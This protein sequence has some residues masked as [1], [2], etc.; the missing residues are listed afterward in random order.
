[1]TPEQR[2]E[3][4]YALACAARISGLPWD[5][6][7]P[8]TKFIDR[9]YMGSVGSDVNSTGSVVQNSNRLAGAYINGKAYFS[10]LADKPIMAH[11]MTHYLQDANDMEMGRAD[12]AGD[13]LKTRRE[14][15]AQAYDVQKLTP[16]ECL[17]L[18][19]SWKSDLKPRG[20]MS[21]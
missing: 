9:G 4:E 21:E 1:M 16:F 19:G 3:I 6:S 13:G 14:R 12:Q 2:A 8:P 11:E 15:E 20:L 5:G 7:V 18:F 17:T 10:Q